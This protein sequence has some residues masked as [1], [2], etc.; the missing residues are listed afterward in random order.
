MTQDFCTGLLLFRELQQ[1]GCFF[2]S[3]SDG[4]FCDVTKRKMKVSLTSQ[5]AS[6]DTFW[7]DSYKLYISLAGLV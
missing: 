7:C 2:G 6:D 5:H 1:T 4:W 3:R